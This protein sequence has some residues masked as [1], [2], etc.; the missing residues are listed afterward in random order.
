MLTEHPQLVYCPDCHGR[1]KLDSSEINPGMTMVCLLCNGAGKVMPRPI[2]NSTPALYDEPELPEYAVQYN[3]PAPSCG[4]S[5][6]PECKGSGIRP[7]GWMRLP[8]GWEHACRSCSPWPHWLEK[9]ID[10]QQGR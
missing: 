5:Q 4:Y 1:G 3:A 8:V 7:D 10:S 9:Y 6:C 2:D